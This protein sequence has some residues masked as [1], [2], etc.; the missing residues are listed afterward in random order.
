MC[1]TSASRGT[2]LHSRRAAV[3]EWTGSLPPAERGG[4][5]GAPLAGGI[6]PIWA[7]GGYLQDPP[8]QIENP[9][10]FFGGGLK[11]V[12]CGPAIV[13]FGGGG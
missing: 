12:R 4:H 3:T 7:L 2:S 13:L 5:G 1:H 9:I 10:F 8:P 11:N 6:P